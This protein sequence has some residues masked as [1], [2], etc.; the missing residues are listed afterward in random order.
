MQ[1]YRLATLGTP[2]GLVL[3]EEDVPTPGPTEIV[4]RIH[5]ASINRRDSMILQKR[6]PLPSMPNVVPLSDGAGEVVAIGAAVTRF[7][8]GD[9]VTGSYFPRWRDGRITP[10]LIDQ[11][12]CTLDGMLTEFARLDEQWAVALPEHLNWE[13]AATLTCAGLT[14][15]N[16]TAGQH[17]L[18]LG[19]SVLLIGTGG[20]S[21]FALQFARLL[22]CRVVVV[23]S[24][25]EKA[26]RL[27]ALGA[28]HVID[29]TANPRWGS[30]VAELTGGGADLVVETGGPD[31]IAQSMMAVA[32]YGRIV[33]LITRSAG[34]PT[35]DIPGDVYGR[36]LATFTR[37]FVGNRAELE[38]MLRAVDTHRLKP[39]IDRTF[40]F[41]EARQAYRYFMQGD[42]FGKVVIRGH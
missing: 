1:R 30:I 5:A 11:P 40:A 42:V 38:A 28:D 27:K 13:E 23:T 24:R 29:S 21:L 4:V 6:Y 15:W 8:P 35:L 17:V 31:T 26:E 25:I 2:D 7:K 12:G 16:A 33:L 39:V 9:R 14:A 36:S 37:L 18:Q 34:K 19:Q 3:V 32:R 22:G 20:V 10:D 41:A